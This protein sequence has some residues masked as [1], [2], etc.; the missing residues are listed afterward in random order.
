MVLGRVF[1][2]LPLPFQ[3]FVIVTPQW[4]IRGRGL[5]IEGLIPLGFFAYQFEN[6]Y[7]LALLMTVTPPPPLE[8]FLP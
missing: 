2:G 7:G 8:E 1:Q 6:S 4:C 5:Y 3:H